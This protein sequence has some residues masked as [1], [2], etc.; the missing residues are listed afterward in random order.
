[1]AAR[2]MAREVAR[3]LDVSGV[4]S[5]EEF[6]TVSTDTRALKPG[7]LFVALRGERFDGADFVEQAHARGARGAVVSADR[8]D[9]TGLPLTLFPVPDTTEALGE[10][11]RHYRR[12][13][14]ARVLA[15]TGSSGKTT[16]KE[17]IALAVGAE[18]AV[19][20]TSGNLNNQI[21]VPLSMLAAPPTSEVWILE[22]GTSAPGEIARLTA[23]AEP[24]DAVVTTVGPAH[25]EGF[26][27]VSGV[28]RE[29]LDLLRGAAPT[30]TVV[31]GELPEALPRAARTERPDTVVAGLGKGCDFRPDDWSFGPTEGRFRHTGT[32]YAVPAGGEHHL[33]DAVIAVAAARAL[34]VSP[35]G[36]ARGLKRFRPLGMRSDVRQI[37]G[38]TLVADCYN[39]NPESFEAAIRFCVDAFPGRRLVA[40][41]GTMLE[42]GAAEVDA[43]RTVARSLARAGFAAVIAVGAFA[44]AFSEPEPTGDLEVVPAVDA[45]EAAD[46]IGGLLRGDEVVLVK[47][48]RG[49]RLE[50]VVE[51]L[52]HGAGGG[53]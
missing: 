15:V 24:E 47:G 32:E 27:D 12:R 35:A 7:A 8:Q 10:L 30:G 40:V 17:M 2:F 42:L 34:G 50:A 25:L 44:P 46:L 16:V 19:H 41:A 3:V 13:S 39:A 37:G 45:G 21:G 9:L 53:A 18:R 48:S 38:L 31:V 14:G 23:I 29:K 20:S 36:A 22:L 28:L 43:H 52:L 49:V 11:A 26:G 6:T 5:D 33:R 51:R 4:S 1:M